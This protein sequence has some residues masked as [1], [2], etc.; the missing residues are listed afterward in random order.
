MRTED[1]FR[2]RIVG[3]D[4]VPP[5]TLLANPAN[6]RR[7]PK[8]QAAALDEVL[9]RVGWV[10]SVIVNQ[11]TGLLVDGHLRVELA[12]HRGE[13][14]V[15]VAF[16]D[17]DEAEE[18]L[19]LATLDPLAG[20]AEADRDQLEALLQGLQVQD[21]ALRTV[22]GALASENGIDLAAALDGTLPD[23]DLEDVPEPPVVPTTTPGELII[24]GRH[25][26][27]CADA[28]RPEA[29]GVLLDG[30]P[31]DMVW[32]DPPYNV[33]Y[34]GKTADALT[35][36]NDA[37]DNAAFRAFLLAFFDIARAVTKPGGPIYVAH[38]DSEGL[39]FRGAMQEGGWLLK[40][41]LVWV[42][43][44]FVLGRQDYHW[45][46]EPILYGWAPG[47]AHAW[48]GDRTQSTVLRFDRPARNG[49]HPTMKP[50]GL[51]AACLK[52]SSHPGDLVLDPFGGSG[53]TL[54]AAEK[55]GRAARLLELDPRYCDVI[56]A[57]WE[58]VTGRR[59]E[60][61][62]VVDLSL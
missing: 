55:T 24:L 27:H 29:Y 48:A 54:I 14:F 43:Q 10:Q 4:Q 8:Q 9:Q 22:L 61:R 13:P 23:E 57:R 20:L 3:H 41:C 1:V 7:H 42:K 32:T 34:Q 58:R 15:P 46:H 16:V 60:R 21:A 59:A 35:I 31:A 53:T 47:A 2:S 37:M 33:A 40:Q 5:E 45:Q 44:A 38:A 39:N 36:Q 18:A 28:T 19:I 11:R 62:Q 52:N 49:D 51:V 12:K 50:V 6:W 56:V 26:L 17:L 30:E 25:R